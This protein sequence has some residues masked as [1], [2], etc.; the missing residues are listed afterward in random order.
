M[1]KIL[2]FFILCFA[3]MSSVYAS[4]IKVQVNGNILDF[5]D[6][7]GAKVDAQIINNRTM[8]PFRKIFNSLGVVDEN[9]TWIGETRTVIAKKDNVEIELQIDNNLAKKTV[10]GETTTITL[11]SAPVIYD[12][13]TLV[14]VRFIAESLDKFVG[15][16]AANKTAIII[17]FGYF[18]DKIKSKSNNLYE[19]INNESNTIDF[20]ITRNYYDLDDSSMNNN[21]I[22]SA[23]IT[24]TQNNDSVTDN[25]TVKFS[26]TNELIKEMIS[27]GWSTMKLEN[28]YYE[29]YLITKALNDGLKKVYG[30]DQMK[31]K[32]SALNCSGKYND[33]FAGA[34]KSI[35]GI[36]ENNVTITTF[37]ELD[38]D[39]SGFLRVLKNTNLTTLKTEKIN[40]NELAIKYFDFTNWDNIIYGSSINRSYN[41]LNSQLFKFDMILEELCYDYSQLDCTIKA[42]NSE[43]NIDFI[44]V[45]EYNEKVQYIIKINK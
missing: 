36:D 8:V 14:P 42:T 17:D 23:Q 25:I 11:D 20:S 43:L 45:N 34:I 37:K 32:Y 12:N 21:V 27:E 39:V 1:K 28:T 10:S 31:F 19:F 5:T 7:N 33:D 15:W 30:Q 3:L 40:S 26:G 41:F 44:G 16:D 4:D 2:V 18:V 29:D 24:E 38:E 22:V 13:R 35:C 6:A 9:I